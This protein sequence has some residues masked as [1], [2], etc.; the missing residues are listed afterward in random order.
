MKLNAT[1][2][3][4]VVNIY[5]DMQDVIVRTRSY[6][7]INSDELKEALKNMRNDMGVRISD[8]ALHQSGLMILKVKEVHMM[9]NKYNPTR[10]GKYINLPKWISLKK[11]RINIKNKDEKCFKYAIQCG[12]HKIY[13]KSH[14]QNFYHHKKIDDDLN[15]AGV[16]F[17]ANNNDIDKFEELNH[18]VSVNVFEV[19][20]QQE[21]IVISRKLNFQMLNVI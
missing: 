14:P 8:M 13:E 1:V 9:F 12:Y 7:I 19:D 2:K 6:T 20:G 5:D 18:N 10:A 15:L 16:N 11:A 21:Q 17:P 4:S 3:I